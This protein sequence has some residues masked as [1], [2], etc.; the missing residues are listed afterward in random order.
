[1]LITG[2]VDNDGVALDSAEM[3]DPTTGQF[4]PAGHMTTSRYGH[5]A[6]L[7][8]DGDVL[9]A[10]GFDNAGSSLASAEL[11][12]AASGKFSKIASMPRDRFFVGG[13]V[14]TSTTILI[15]GGYTQ[16]PSG[17]GSVCEKPVKTALIFD[18]KSDMF[19]SIPS[20]KS[21]RGSFASTPLQ[22]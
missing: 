5:L 19:R 21:A 13:T 10:G 16:C 17:V 9:V 4:S 6:A 22:H 3:Y 7:L 1:M 18:H 8:G 2:G 14:L 11:F 15:A 12:V 20:M